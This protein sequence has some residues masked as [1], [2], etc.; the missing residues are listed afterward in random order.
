MTKGKAKM[1]L[2]GKPIQ[3]PRPRSDGDELANLIDR[4]SDEIDPVNQPATEPNTKQNGD[5]SGTQGR[6]TGVSRKT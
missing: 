3:K 1:P 5:S 6:E 2:P 4:Y